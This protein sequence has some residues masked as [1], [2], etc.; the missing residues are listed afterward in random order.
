MNEKSYSF[1]NKKHQ[2][3]K[4][5]NEIR[6]IC[7][8]FFT[9]TFF[10]FFYNIFFTRVDSSYVVEIKNSIYHNKQYLI[11]IIS[12]YLKNKNFIFISPREISDNLN[13]STGLISEVVVRKYIVPNFKL[14]A[15]VKEKKILGRLILNNNKDPDSLAFAP[16]YITN[17]GDLLPLKLLN[18]Q[19]LPQKLINVLIPD[20]RIPAK[21]VLFTLNEVVDRLKSNFHLLVTRIYLDKKNNLEIHTDSGLRIRL[22]ELDSDVFKR[23]TK[24]QGILGVLNQK[25]Y[26]N[27]YLDLTLESNAVFKKLPSED[28]NKEPPQK[29]GFLRRAKSYRFE[30]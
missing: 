9:V 5:R 7:L 25:S 6:R 27:G 1:S 13:K 28:I 23:I 26:T 21:S 24:L 30:H 11:D 2:Y 10:Y 22:G 14:I 18:F 16:F 3:I 19:S 15:F 4:R 29:K 17:E 20:N 12:D 8:L